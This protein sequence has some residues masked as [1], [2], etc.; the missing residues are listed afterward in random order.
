MYDLCDYIHTET[1]IHSKYGT[2]FYD[3]HVALPDTS[4]SLREFEMQLLLLSVD[5]KLNQGH[6]IP[7]SVFCW[8]QA[9]Q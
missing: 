4:C 8:L 2:P 7:A 9:S 3:L 6:R 1:N 5:S